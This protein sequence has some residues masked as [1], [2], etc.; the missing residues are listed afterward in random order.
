[1]MP[2]KEHILVVDDEPQV[3][4]ALE[5]LLSERFVVSKAASAEEA[6][7]FM[8]ERHDVAVLITDQRMPRITG[9]ELLAR[10]DPGN[11]TQRIMV[12]GY[13]DL[14]A[15]VRAVNDGQL[16]AY[17][18]KPWSEDDLLLKVVRASE[19]F[20]LGQ[21][22]ATERRTLR[23][24]TTVLNAV[25]D[26]MREG[27]LVTDREGRF[28][29]FNEEARRILGVTAEPVRLADWSQAYG[30]YES[31]CKT[32]LRPENNPLVLAAA[33]KDAPE[34]ELYVRNERVS[35]AQI[36]VS[37]TPLRI[38][39]GVNGAV[40]LLRDVSERR[41]LEAQLLQ[42]QKMEA[43]GQLAGGVAHDFNNLLSVIHT[44]G[45][46]ILAD[47]QDKPQVHED[48]NELLGAA[49]RATSLT[50][51]LLA[52]SRDQPA[53]EAPVDL[54]GLVSNVEKMLGRVIGSEIVL[55]SKLAPRVGAI[56]ADETQLEQIVLNLA[57]NARDA[58][59]NG[60]N[61]TITT[62]EVVLSDVEERG[63][64]S[65]RFV[66]MSVADTG[67]GM[68]AEV[69][70]RIF[71]P[72]FTTKPVGMGTGL[73]LSTVYG[74]VRKAGG[75]IAVESELGR[76]TCFRVYLPLPES[77]PSVPGSVPPQGFG[78]ETILLVENEEAVLRVA[79]RILRERGYTVL[80]AAN[81]EEGRRLFSRHRSSVELVAVDAHLQ[82]ASGAELAR[83][84]VRANPLVKVLYL[85]AQATAIETARAEQKD[86]WS[87]LAKPFTPQSLSAAVRLL[88]GKSPVSSLP[89]QA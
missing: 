25:L 14:T 70:Q 88:L 68:S 63:L 75:H 27:V 43:I 29:I 17:V 57:I 54:N 36:V 41:L 15:V 51:Q 30:I 77:A 31:D 72:F 28:L 26:A 18:T 37:A 39:N 22:L 32:P 62:D 24:Q 64:P 6:L 76:G 5:D 66:L 10:L 49:Q 53:H 86:D 16:F 7:Q 71:E 13:A 52:F 84:F 11:D 35:G 20:R 1:M 46:L 67:S 19:Q 50:K 34:I 83:E 73:G 58:M 55:E 82:E 80:E 47:T 23:E 45:E 59:P 2:A 42:A 69:Q 81:V 8:A 48:M 89:P 78:H 79:S 60:G 87:Y 33:G 74:I 40:A 9:D 85:A 44:Y 65:G 3:L 4:V 56:I 38:A 21:Q 12:T 61:L